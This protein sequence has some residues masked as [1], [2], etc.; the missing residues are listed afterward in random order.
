MR[1][2]RMLSLTLK[3]YAT[4]KWSSL[5]WSNKI[6]CTSLVSIRSRNRP[7][8][9]LVRRAVFR[10]KLVFF[11]LV[12][13][14]FPGRKQL[15]PTQSVNTKHQTVDHR[16]PPDEPDELHGLNSLVS[17]HRV[18]ISWDRVKVGPGATSTSMLRATPGFLRIIPVRSRVRTIW[19][20]EG[21]LTPKCRC[22]SASAGGRPSRCV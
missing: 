16:Y 5:I 3:L 9:H 13:H 14:P 15:M 7:E 17:R 22:R 12:A 21:G 18:L 8:C 10:Q 4:P 11:L 1:F 20:T 6:A 2:A 19:W